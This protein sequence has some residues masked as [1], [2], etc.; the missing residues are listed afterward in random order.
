MNRD[1][2]TMH[3]AMNAANRRC[4]AVRTVPHPTAV[5]AEIILVINK[6]WTFAA[7]CTNYGGVFHLHQ[8]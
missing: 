4:D 7:T 3:V 8:Y 5:P 2:H 1:A 6:C